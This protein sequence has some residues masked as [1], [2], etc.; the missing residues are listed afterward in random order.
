MDIDRHSYDAY[1]RTEKILSSRVADYLRR[2][3]ECDSDIRRKR[4]DILEH[5]SSCSG[6]Y[7]SDEDDQRHPV[8]KKFFASLKAEDIDFVSS[9]GFDEHIKYYD[10]GSKKY[11]V[12][13]ILRVGDMLCG[14]DCHALYHS[15]Q[16]GYEAFD[17]DMEISFEKDGERLSTGGDDY[18][19]SGMSD[20]ISF[21]S[22]MLTYGVFYADIYLPENPL[23]VDQWNKY[24]DLF[25][26][27]DFSAL[28]FA[29]DA[30]AIRFAEFLLSEGVDPNISDKDGNTPLMISAL[31]KNLEMTQFLLEKGA[32]P[33]MV[34][35]KNMS[36]ESLAGLK[37][38]D[39]KEICALIEKHKI[40]PKTLRRKSCR[41]QDVSL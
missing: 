28:H 9:R 24:F 18:K 15:D 23:N 25:G 37:G 33:R 14:V 3:G 32:D 7:I 19:A 17:E 2:I 22:E 39:C 38:G 1:V 34:N 29:A 11:S 16:E 5:F 41:A 26:G 4:L 13:V 12:T 21:F 35:N 10:G 8:V 36:P 20:V 30:G 6:D 31:N 27:S 40:T